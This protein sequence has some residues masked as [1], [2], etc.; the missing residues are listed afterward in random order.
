[1]ANES[2]PPPVRKAA[3]VRANSTAWFL[4]PYTTAPGGQVNR[5]QGG[6][7]PSPLTGAGRVG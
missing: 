5:I 6:P 4:G 7:G 1:M 2:A 3:T